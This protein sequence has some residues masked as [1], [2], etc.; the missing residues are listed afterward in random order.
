MKF[1]ILLFTLTFSISVFS[2]QKTYKIGVYNN[3]QKVNHEA[4]NNIRKAWELAG[5]NIEFIDLPAER[6]LRSAATGKIDADIF[7]FASSVENYLEL[8]QIP[9]PVASNNFW[10]YIL[11]S[12]ECFDINQLDQQTPVAVFGIRYFKKAYASS[13]KSYEEVESAQQAL[14]MIKNNRAQYIIASE[15]VMNA[16]L[17]ESKFQLKKCFEQPV[18]T[19]LAYTYIHSNNIDILDKLTKS[20]RQVFG[21]KTSTP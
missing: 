11:A 7:R 2:H 6:S 5:I 10:V 13:K 19:D 15:T 1:I 4:V 20:Y 21:N 14:L 16:L 12:K 17:N 8:I 18:F 3:I 9:V